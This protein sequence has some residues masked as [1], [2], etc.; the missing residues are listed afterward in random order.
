MS[1][2]MDSCN[3]MRGSKSGL[4]VRLRNEKA[5]RLLDIDGDFCHHIHNA[6]KVFSK[7]FGGWVEDYLHNI[8]IDFNWSVDLKE[9]LEKI[10]VISNILL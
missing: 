6:S 3:I 1:V 7:P 4:K 2:L 8:Y 5:P 9:K 10:C